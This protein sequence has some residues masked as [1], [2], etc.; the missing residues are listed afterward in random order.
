MANSS[1]KTNGIYVEKV[2]EEAEKNRYGSP[3]RKPSVLEEITLSTIF[4]RLITVILFPNDDVNGASEPLLMRI[5]SFLV[6]NGPLLQAAFENSARDLILWTRR[7]SPFRGLF[8]VSVGTVVLLAL[9]GLLAFML[10]FVV[11]TVNALVVYLLLSLAAVGVFLAIFLLSVA[12]IYVAA[13][14]VA[15]FVIST[16]TIAAIVAAL[17]TTGWI[18]FFWTLWQG[19]RKGVEMAK[20][21]LF[22]NGPVESAYSSSLSTQ[23][24]HESNNLS[25]K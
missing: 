8:V 6:Q 7:G 10:F 15:V 4:S 9:T 5:R 1:E 12:A 11:F 16:T 18:G 25:N 17:V 22:A 13:V 21:S 19:T 2:G 3:E 24:Y 20:R 23:H 14:T